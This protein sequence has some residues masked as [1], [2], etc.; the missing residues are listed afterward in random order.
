MYVDSMVWNLLIPQCYCHR[1]HRSQSFRGMLTQALLLFE[2]SWRLHARLHQGVFGIEE[3]VTTNRPKTER[4][5]GT[6][7][8]ITTIIIE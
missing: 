5:S 8:I 6:E 2:T 1:S 4:K 3:N 7:Y